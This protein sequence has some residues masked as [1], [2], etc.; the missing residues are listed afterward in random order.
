MWLRKPPKWGV[1]KGIFTRIEFLKCLYV[2]LLSCFSLVW[3]FTTLWIVATQAP[4]SIYGILQARILEWV[5]MPPSRGSSWPKD[6]THISCFAGKFFTHWA[7][8]KAQKSVWGILYLTYK[9]WNIKHNKINF[10]EWL[11]MLMG[12]STFFFFFISDSYW[13]AKDFFFWKT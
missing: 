6:W 3:L 1:C 2:C 13:K 5:A 11:R 4:S 9:Q 12:D 10:F 7:T 8:W